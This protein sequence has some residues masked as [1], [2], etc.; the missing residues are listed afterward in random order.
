MPALA[1]RVCVSFHCNPSGYSY[2]LRNVWPCVATSMG[3]CGIPH[4][5]T[6]YVTCRWAWSLASGLPFGTMIEHPLPLRSSIQDDRLA[7][8]GF[9]P[10]SGC[11]SMLGAPY[12]LAFHGESGKR[13]S[14]FRRGGAVILRLHVG[15]RG[16]PAHLGGPWPCCVP[17]PS[18]AVATAAPPVISEARHEAEPQQQAI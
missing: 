16:V 2:A 10:K 14:F 6:S 17:D 5:T 9:L 13:S 1:R 12:G 3:F 11:A 15:C 18:D 7:E 4:G 8:L